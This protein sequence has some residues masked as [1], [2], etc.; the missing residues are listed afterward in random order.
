[1]MPAASSMVP[2]SMLSNAI[3]RVLRSGGAT[4]VKRGLR[5]LWWTVK[6]RGIANPPLPARVDA[7]LFVCLGN[8]CR[9]P[10]AE[11]I[12]SERL[13]GSASPRRVSSAGIRTR[14]AAEAPPD[15]RAVASRYGV[16]LDE[17]R[18]RP[19]TEQLMAAHDMVIVMESS[20]MDLLRR[21]YP[22]HAER[23]FL[24]SLFDAEAAGADRYTIMDPFGSPR[25]VFEACYAR[26]DRTVVSLLST[27]DQTAAAA[28]ARRR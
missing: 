16:S 1:M 6:G 28:D 26:I 7:L 23:V 14:Q 3:T 10:F 17:H 5:N 20:Q 4:Q 25:A 22:R 13:R 15:A 8:I 21:L 2:S 11:V 12:A 24:L 9:S 27:L 19:L 18:P